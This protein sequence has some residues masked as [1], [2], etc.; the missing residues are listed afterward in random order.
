MIQM[1]KRIPLKK[2]I[3]NFDDCKKVFAMGY[4]HYKS[5]RDVAILQKIFNHSSPA[6]TSIYI[7]INQDILDES[8]NNFIL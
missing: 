1:G 2:F 8:Y 5:N 6:I 7:G 3:K 4:W